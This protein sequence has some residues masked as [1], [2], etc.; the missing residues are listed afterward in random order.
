MDANGGW[1]ASAVDLIRF[2]AALDD[3]KKCPILSEE[4]IRTM[5]APPPGP[6]GHGP[7]GGR[8]RSTTRAA[9]TFGRPGQPGK[10]TKWHTGMLAGSSTLLVCRDDGIDWAVLFNSD[11][12]KDGKQFADII[13][14]L[15][16]KPANE[17]K[18]WP[19]IDLFPRF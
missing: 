10:Y 14:P 13:D 3:P 4:S 15:L 2:A 17:I 1:I 11:A 12:G 6:V 16:H 18:D 19:V 5:L 8:S 9:G 7:R